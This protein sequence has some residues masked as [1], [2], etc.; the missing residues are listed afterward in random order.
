MSG[1][2]AHLRGQNLAKRCAK[3]RREGLPLTEVAQI[4]GVTREQVAAKIKL[5]ERLLSLEEHQ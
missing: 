4:A 2:G 5:G 1:H 3:L